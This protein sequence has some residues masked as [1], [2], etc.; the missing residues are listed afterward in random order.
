MR[1]LIGLIALVCCVNIAAA[2]TTAPADPADPTAA[3]TALRNDLIDS[4][5]KGDLPRLLSHLDDEVVVTWQNAEVCHGPTEVKQYY[6][7]MMSGPDRRVQSVSAEPKVTG[8]RVMGDWAITWGEMNDHFVLTDGMEISPNSHFT[9]TT[10]KRGGEW[11]V[12]AFHVSM[13]AFDNPIIGYA[14]K[15][16]MLV[17]ATV[18]SLGGLLIG[19]L[20][21]RA[22]RR[23]K[24]V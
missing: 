15:K 5:N 18:A 22:L 7:K 4:F 2:Q 21:S 13:N 16:S 1:R 3:I 8:R 9:A 19:F 11:K 14:V 10:V 17:A 12:A 24:E 20:A 6:D 23:S